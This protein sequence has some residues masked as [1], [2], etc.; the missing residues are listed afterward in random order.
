M[1]AAQVR[2]IFTLPCQVG[3]YYSRA[4][5]LASSYVEWF[6]PFREPDPFSGLCQVSHST[7]QLQRNAAMVLYLLTILFVQVTFK[8]FQRWAS[9]LIVD[10]RVEMSMRQQMISI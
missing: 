2:V 9:R 5:A 6:T 8:L 3:A 1:R 7:R 10:E 4:M